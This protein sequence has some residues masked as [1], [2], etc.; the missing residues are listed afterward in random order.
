MLDLEPFTRFRTQQDVKVLRHK[1]TRLDLWHLR[2]CGRRRTIKGR[3]RLEKDTELKQSFQDYQNGQSWDVFGTARYLISF[4]AERH[5][6]AKLVG[7][8]EVHSKAR[9]VGGGYEYET[10]E[11]PGFESLER[12]LVV[13]WGQGTRSWAQWLHRQGN[14]DV[15]EILPRN[16]VA[17]FRGFYD[18]AL[19]H[20]E[21]VKMV[22]NA[23]ANREWHRMLSSISGVYL[24]V[25]QVTG[26]QY[27]GSAYGAGGIWSRW[28]AYAKNPSGGNRLLKQLLEKE[29]ERYKHFQFSV[30]RV[31]EPG[32]PKDA[33]IEQEVWA[34]RKLGCRAHGLN[35]N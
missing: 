27:V 10:T 18:F 5:K 8:W 29:P 23:E 3:A 1:D 13:L 7:V 12:R 9:K 35:G 17:D 21:L 24:M 19:T 25:D 32:V 16:Y 34:K 33:V 4:I 14:K 28:I 15:S 6:Y 26:K 31:L 30:L 11:L 2:A 22:N 20:D